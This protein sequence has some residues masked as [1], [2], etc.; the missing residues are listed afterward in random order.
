[1][2]SILHT[3]DWHLGQTFFGFD[4]VAEHIHFLKWL[5]SKLVLEDI[6]VLLISGD[7]FDVSNPSAQAQ[8]QFYKFIQEVT[9]LLPFI[10]IIVIAGNHDSASRLEAPLPLVE[11]KRTYIKGLIHYYIIAPIFLSIIS[12]YFWVSRML[13][14]VFTLKGEIS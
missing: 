6:D 14:S 10:Q 1:M 4:R 11:D 7:I 3:A 8:R 13:G 2:I 5:K 12:V 9:E